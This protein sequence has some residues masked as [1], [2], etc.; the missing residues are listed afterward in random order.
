MAKETF[1]KYSNGQKVKMTNKEVKQYIMKVNKWTSDQYNKQ[2][3]IIRNKLRA[4]ESYEKASG[5]KVEAQSVQGLLYKEARAKKREGVNYK[6][7]IKMQRIRSFT[8]VSSGKKGQEALTHKKYMSRRTAMYEDATYKQFSGL[9]NNNSQARFI[10]ESIKDPVKREK[11]LAD[12]ANMI[13]AKINEQDE[14]EENEA[15]PF[16][17]TYGSDTA[18]DFDITPYL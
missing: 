9:I 15:I 11:A 12:Y 16:G 18:F 7:S 3:D 2:Y 14:I 17:E 1:Y 4:Y 5:K 6:P 13:K 10:Y 8:S